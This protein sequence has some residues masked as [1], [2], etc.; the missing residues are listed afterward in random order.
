M[1]IYL[2]SVNFCASDVKKAASLRVFRK[3]GHLCMTE[4]NCFDRYMTGRGI[5]P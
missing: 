5:W 3:G 4:S 1:V 2:F